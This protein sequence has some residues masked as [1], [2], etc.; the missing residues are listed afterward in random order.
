[1]SET[2]ENLINSETNENVD[3]PKKS[4]EV[5]K[6]QELIAEE[7]EN[8]VKVNGLE[9]KQLNEKEANESNDNG[10]EETQPNAL[11]IEKTNG[12]EEEKEH[13]W[14]DLLGS[15]SLMKKIVKEG[16]PDSRPMRL[17]KC[18]INYECRLEDGTLVEEKE[19]FE[20]LLGDC[21]V[22]IV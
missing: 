1:M 12:V 11:Q 9:D 7:Q 6:S 21:E 20:M 22:R 19:N 15:G 13:D 18:I 5:E 4:K 16:E 3:I 2:S 10:I 17:E 8:E 14:E